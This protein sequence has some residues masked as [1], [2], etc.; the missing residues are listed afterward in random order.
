MA[1]PSPVPPGSALG[2][3]ETLGLVAAVEAADAMLKASDVRLVRQQRTVPGLVTHFV[4]GETAAVRSAVDAGAAAAERV[5]RVAARHVIPRPADDV[6]RRLVGVVPGETAP[7]DTG[8]KN[9]GANSGSAPDADADETPGAEPDTA[10]A[11]AAGAEPDADAAPD[12]TAPDAGA[13]DAGAADAGAATASGSEAPD[14]AD[15]YDDL[16]VRE[17]RRLARD[18]DDEAFR[19]RAIARA[20]KDELVDFLRRADGA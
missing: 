9:T 11:G 10:D 1:A 19:G 14:G 6:W 20:S 17:L 2:M 12:A 5:G 13:A 7:P 16:T 4:V 15:D 18:R 3:L 8:P